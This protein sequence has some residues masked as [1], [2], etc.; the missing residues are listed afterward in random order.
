MIASLPLEIANTIVQ[1][2]CF[3]N[4]AIHSPTQFRTFGDINV[5]IITIYLNIHQRC[6][7]F[8]Q[9]SRKNITKILYRVTVQLLI[10]QFKVNLTDNGKRQWKYLD[11]ANYTKRKVGWI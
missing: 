11:Q 10:P 8:L 4:S 5:K 6:T 9:L 3:S 2:L 1:F 7:E